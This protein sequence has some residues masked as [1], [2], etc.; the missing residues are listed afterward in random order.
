MRLSAFHCEIA[1]TGPTWVA[2]AFKAAVLV[3][4]FSSLLQR[5]RLDHSQQ[6]PHW[7]GGSCE[8]TV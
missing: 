3:G 7:S 2:A 6:M 5:L 8:R 1:P 4:E